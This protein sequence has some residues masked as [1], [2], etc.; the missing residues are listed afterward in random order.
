[1]ETTTEVHTL[2]IKVITNKVKNREGS[3]N[4]PDWCVAWA[5]ANGQQIAQVQAGERITDEAEALEMLRARLPRVSPP[6]ST[7]TA[8]TSI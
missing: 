8:G 2:E 3:V 1:M 7:T 4:A 5:F 6:I